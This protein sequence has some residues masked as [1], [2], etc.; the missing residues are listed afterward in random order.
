L[1]AACLQAIASENTLENGADRGIIRSVFGNDLYRQVGQICD[2]TGARVVQD[3]IHRQDGKIAM[4]ARKKK[5]QN[6]IDKVSANQPLDR[7]SDL[8]RQV[9]KLQEDV[10]LLKMANPSPL[11]NEAVIPGE[12]EKP[13]DRK[14]TGPKEKID[15]YDLLHTRNLMISWLESI[16]PAIVDQLE[17]ARHPRHVRALFEEYAVQRDSRP[18]WQTRFMKKPGALIK[19]LWSD[20]YGKTLSRATVVHALTLPFDDERRAQAANRLPTRRIANAM[21]GVPDLQWRTS[22][23]KCSQRPSQARVAPNT[24]FYYRRQYGLPA[25]IL[26]PA[27]NVQA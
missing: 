20:R 23:D 7:I 24:E 18:G 25:A 1:S 12:Q 8:E 6:P 26:L 16:W 19:F 3:L 4:N 2:F 15:D 9:L 21:A 5:L 10:A 27:S 22:F 17:K 13:E 11:L 14:R